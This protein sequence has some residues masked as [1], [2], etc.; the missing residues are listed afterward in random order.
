MKDAP[1]YDIKFKPLPIKKQD[2][3]KDQIF[4]L[5]SSP[6]YQEP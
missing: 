2:N 5:E 6:L 1:P 4:D 3:E